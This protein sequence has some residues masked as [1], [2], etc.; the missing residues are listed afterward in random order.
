MHTSRALVFCPRPAK[1]HPPGNLALLL[2]VGTIAGLSILDL[3][4]LVAIHRLFAKGVEDLNFEIVSC[5][6]CLLL[7]V[8]GMSVQCTSQK[9]GAFAPRAHSAVLCSLAAVSRPTVFEPSSSLHQTLIEITVVALTAACTA[10]CTAGVPRVPAVRLL[11][12]PRGHVRQ[13]GGRQGLRPPAVCGADH[14]CGPP[15][16]VGVVGTDGVLLL[17]GLGHAG[18]GREPRSRRQPRAAAVCPRMHAGRS[19][20]VAANMGATLTEHL[21]WLVC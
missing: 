8:G 13:G 19:W 20:R 14:V 1:T 10:A 21:D 12:Q 15:V 2:Q 5:C 16:G 7:L 9:G 11:R 4:L 6:C 3:I 18:R 17:G